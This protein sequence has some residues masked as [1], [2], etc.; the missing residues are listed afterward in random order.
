M[1]KCP[2]RK[3][4]LGIERREIFI[5]MSYDNNVLGYRLQQGL[6]VCIRGKQKNYIWQIF[7]EKEF[8]CVES[9]KM[10]ELIR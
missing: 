5:I 10:P 3:K 8:F 7:Y 4:T 2:L 9:C 6:E 1:S